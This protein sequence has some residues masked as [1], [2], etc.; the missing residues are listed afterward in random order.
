M[1]HRVTVRLYDDNILD[2]ELL[3][4]LAECDSRRK[5]ELIRTFL[6]V[7][8]NQIMSNRSSALN[9]METTDAVTGLYSN[10]GVEKRKEHV[11]KNKADSKHSSDDS[12]VEENHMEVNEDNNKS[13]TTT[14]DV[15]NEREGLNADKDVKEVLMDVDP[16]LID[17][18][19]D[20]DDMFNPLGALAKKFS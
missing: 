13:E 19:E 14:L 11:R 4:A 9:A 2:A 16:S 7:G 1:L 15:G 12:I 5:Q 6:R 17:D 8:F 18:E 10:S 20:D 3:D